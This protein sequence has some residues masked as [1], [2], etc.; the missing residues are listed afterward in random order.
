MRMTALAALAGLAL[1]A[2]ATTENGSS[3]GARA[4]MVAG[5]QYCWLAR[6]DTSGGKHTCNW[7]AD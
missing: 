5:T 6:L 2:C 4:T 7:A 1:A 3:A